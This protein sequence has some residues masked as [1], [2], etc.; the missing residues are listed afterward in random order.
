MWKERCVVAHTACGKSDSRQRGGGFWEVGFGKLHDEVVWRRGREEAMFT[1]MMMV[2][3][4]NG[5]DGVSG[6]NHGK[7]VKIVIE[8]HSIIRA[9]S[10]V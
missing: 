5:N 3:I 8:V 10:R 1:M 7:V 6:P 9:C 4:M 2:M